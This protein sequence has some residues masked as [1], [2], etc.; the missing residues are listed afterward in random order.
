MLAALKRAW[1]LPLSLMVAVGISCSRDPEVAKREYLASG[2]QFLSQGRAREA[3]VQYRNALRHDPRFGEARYKLAEALVQDGD[4]TRAGREYIRA[5]DLLP[6]DVQAQLKAG[7][8]LLFARQFEDATTRA[9]NALALDRKNVDAQILLGN[10]LA[11]L[12]DLEGAV[13]EIQEAI[14]LDP[15]NRLGYVSLAALEHAAGRQAE[16]EAAFKKAIEA[17]PKYVPARLG[18]ANFYWATRRA[19][20]TAQTLREAYTIDPDHPLTNRMLALFQIATGRPGDAEPYF[21]KLAQVSED[22]DAQSILADY[23]IA[24]GRSDKAVPVL[25]QMAS[26]PEARGAA[27]LRLAEL[28]FREGRRPEAQKRLN[29]LLEREPG[30]ASILLLQARFLSAEGRLEEAIDRLQAAAS[31]NPALAEA[32]FALGQAYAAKNDHERAMQAFN[33]TLRL[34]PRAVA[35]QLEL[36]RLELAA[37]RPDSSIQFAEQALKNAPR[38]PEAKLALVRGLM[39]RRDVRRAESE[40]QSL[41]KQYPDDAAVH[42]QAGILSAM[43][44][45]RSGAARTLARALELDPSN[46]DALAALVS[47]DLAEKNSSRA[48]SRVEARL[49]RAP[50][51]P[52]ALV[53]A[54][55]TYGSAGDL[56]KA[57]QALRK[58]IE[59]DS[60]NFQAYGMLGRLYLSQQRL[61]EALAEFD[62][63]SKRQPRP[64]RAHTLAGVILEAQ[65]KPEEARKRY[66]QALAIDP[67]MP[68]AANNL[69]WMYAETGGNLDVALQLAQTATRRLPDDPAIQDTLGWIYYKKGLAALAV[70]PFRR[71]VELDPKNPI[72]HFHLGLAYMKAGDSPKARTALQQ[73]LALAPD[74]AGATEAKQAL[75]SIKG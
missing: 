39:A 71:S 64:V 50:N 17:D 25:E 45:D 29:G 6:K 58:T 62:E 23:Y 13:E 15:N 12:K 75:A 28:D 69:A 35:A 60:V 56:K 61:D 14:K 73:A 44:G 36:A 10:A 30:N 24:T 47:L 27:D 41:I 16:A 9:H 32:Q 66:E 34:N 8:F 1:I 11:G 42:T 21:V 63:L 49:A 31:A 57:E 51:D 59:V 53:L 2:D 55:R 40:L 37:G 22:P 52:G 70:P 67:E 5:A 20:E 48:I 3:I 65:K 33:E 18:L 7:Q 74:F 26:S 38:S 4:W 68:V 54:A 46:L 72:F 19:A 43:K